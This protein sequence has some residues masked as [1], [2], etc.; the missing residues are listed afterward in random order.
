M[1]Y[2]LQVIGQA[3]CGPYSDRDLAEVVVEQRSIGS[4]QMAPVEE[5]VGDLYT[6]LGLELHA[7]VVG[8]HNN[9][10]LGPTDPVAPATVMG[11]H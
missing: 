6:Y 10:G 5:H 8:L 2:A 11:S 1:R 7:D 3:H 4:D 9:S